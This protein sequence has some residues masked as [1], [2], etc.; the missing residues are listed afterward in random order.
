MPS[1]W[2]EMGTVGETRPELSCLEVVFALEGT[3]GRDET[4]T[5]GSVLHIRPV[6][7]IK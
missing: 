1:K 7:K 3:I 5:L 6:D 2:E 4:M